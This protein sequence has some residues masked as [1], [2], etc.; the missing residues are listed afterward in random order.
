MG[1]DILSALASSA[2]LALLAGGLLAVVFVAV[3]PLR[4]WFVALNADAQAALMAWLIIA[5]AAVAIIT[6]CAGVLS[7]IA[8]TSGGVL[9]YIGQVLYVALAGIAG[10][11][12]VF[13]LARARASASA[14]SKDLAPE[15]TPTRGKLLE[16]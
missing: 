2:G 14:S 16:R 3:P 8:C 4:A 15:A 10:N 5:L 12:A 11:R 9:E 13:Q 6:S 7:V 1:I